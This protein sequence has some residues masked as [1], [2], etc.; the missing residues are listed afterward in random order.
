MTLQDRTTGPHHVRPP[1]PD[2]TP[3][4]FGSRRDAIF[5][6]GARLSRR[7]PWVRVVGRLIAVT[8]CADQNGAATQ[9]G[10]AIQVL[11]L[12]LSKTLGLQNS[13]G[14]QHLGILAYRPMGLR[15][16]G[17]T[18]QGR[19]RDWG[20]LDERLAVEDGQVVRARRTG[21]VPSSGTP[22][23]L[24]SPRSASPLMASA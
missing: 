10:Q 17:A 24:A 3:I 1:R 18:R 2:Q 20:L 13:S 8:S 6:C 11:Q 12:E 14:F 22:V 19:D 15:Q 16:R 5:H 7:A 21:A 23:T 9:H 4:D